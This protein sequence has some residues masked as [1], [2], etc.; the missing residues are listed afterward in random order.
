MK[1]VGCMI[2]EDQACET[3]GRPSAGQANDSQA[4]AFPTIPLVAGFTPINQHFSPLAP[5]DSDPAPVSVSAANKGRKRQKK[6]SPSATATPKTTKTPR[7]RQPKKAKQ[8]ALPKEQT[9]AYA[10]NLSKPFGHELLVHQKAGHD[11][12]LEP[13]VQASMSSV[14]APPAEQSASPST[15]GLT[16][17]YQAAFRREGLPL[18]PQEDNGHLLLSLLD[19]SVHRTPRSPLFQ[20]APTSDSVWTEQSHLSEDAISTGSKLKIISNDAAS[21]NG[22]AQSHSGAMVSGQQYL[23][24]PNPDQWDIVTPSLSDF[25]QGVTTEAQPT[26]INASYCDALDLS[27]FDDFL[28]K[29]TEGNSSPIDQSETNGHTS[30]TKCAAEQEV[31][32]ETLP[33]AVT[34]SGT[35]SYISDVDQLQSSYD[36]QLI[37]FS[38]SQPLIESSSPSLRS[39]SVHQLVSNREASPERF[40]L[41]NHSTAED[42][43]D[44][45]EIDTG[46]LDFQSPPS[47]QVP[48]PSPP[49]SPNQKEITKCQLMPPPDPTTPATSPVKLAVTASPSPVGSTS[50]SVKQRPTSQKDIPHEVSFDESGAPI[51]FI[52]PVFPDPIRDRSPVLGLSSRTFLRTCFRIGEALNAGSTALRTRK[53][54]VIELYARVNYSERPDRSVKQHFHFADIF[55]PEK[56]PFLK[57][58]YGLWKGVGLWDLDSKVFLGEKGKGK[59][60]RVVGRIGREEKTRGLEMTVLSI[61]EVDWEDVGICKGHYCT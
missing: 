10:F 38:N 35:L 4:H 42:M 33:E 11:D 7:P 47:A 56:P 16:S 55:A 49:D 45:E 51:P 21:S 54:V 50:A 15:D 61:W 25:T 32:S 46:F 48:P 1:E 58:T 26:V 27:P 28:T 22:L 24:E 39:H 43:Y 41:D 34:G 5:D 6:V 8:A 29:S 19:Q 44:D 40:P 30:E 37:S 13:G 59:M 60:A 57:G 12:I 36:N 52:R 18:V 31:V 9:I 3:A 2:N 14:T 20:P 53:D 17:A 23:L